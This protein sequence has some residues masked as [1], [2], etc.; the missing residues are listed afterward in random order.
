M[1]LLDEAATWAFDKHFEVVMA[2][3]IETRNWF[4]AV[5]DLLGDVEEW[6]YRQHEVVR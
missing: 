4:A 1:S 3:V 5:D 2:C 6:L